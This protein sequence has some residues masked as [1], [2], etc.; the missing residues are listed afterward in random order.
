MLI[1]ILTALSVYF[2]ASCTR[3]VVYRSSGFHCDT[4]DVEVR[5]NLK[6][7]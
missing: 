2:A 5:S 1:S 4:V 7:P 3:K 6:F